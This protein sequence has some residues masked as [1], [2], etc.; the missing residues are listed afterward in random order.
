MRQVIWMA[1]T[2]DEASK[3]VEREKLCEITKSLNRRI[4]CSID[5][6]KYNGQEHGILRLVFENKM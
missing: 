1:S 2:E 5:R 6:V 3:L 4:S